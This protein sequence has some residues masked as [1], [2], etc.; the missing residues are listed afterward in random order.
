MTEI[1]D[2]TVNAY[3]GPLE[4]GETYCLMSYNLRAV[5]CDGTAS[6][7]DLRLT[8]AWT[9]VQIRRQNETLAPSFLWGDDT[10][11]DVFKNQKQLLDGLYRFRVT[12][13]GVK[14]DYA[15]TQSCHIPT[16]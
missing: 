5:T 15:F 12:I 3:V 13:D 4:D 10:K 8:N 1:W 16:L 7:V 6:L 11:G 14:T 2:P 9:G